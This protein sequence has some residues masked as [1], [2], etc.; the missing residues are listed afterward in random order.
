MY[1]KKLLF[2]L[3]F[4]VLNTLGYAQIVTNSTELNNAINAALPGTTI[5]LADGTWKD[6]FINIDK[7]GTAD[8]PITITAQ[9]AGAVLMTGN[10]RVYMEGTYLTVSGLIFQEPANL[11]LDGSDRIEP[12]IE[13]KRCN[14]CKIINNKIDSYNGTEAQKELIFKW[15]LADGQHNEIAYNSFVGKYGGRQY[16]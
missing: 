14:H 5:I 13:L 12:V 4:L 7:N 11:V 15:I 3:A 9:N 8:A 16:H 10:S 6:V 1:T 2:A